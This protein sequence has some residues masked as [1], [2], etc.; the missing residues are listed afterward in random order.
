MIDWVQCTVV[1]FIPQVLSNNRYQM[2][3]GAVSLKAYGGTVKPVSQS[4]DFLPLTINNRF[5]NLKFFFGISR[6]ESKDGQ[7][8]T[9]LGVEKYYTSP[10]DNS[11]RLLLQMETW[12]LTLMAASSFNYIQYKSLK[13]TEPG[14]NCNTTCSKDLRPYFIVLNQCNYCH[15]SCL[16]CNVTNSDNYC[17]KCHVTRIRNSKT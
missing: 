1:Y 3:S 2:N 10:T 15:Y 17:D 4:I 13:C 6:I 5:E 11:V 9:L 7:S 14:A 12:K 8:I 16:T